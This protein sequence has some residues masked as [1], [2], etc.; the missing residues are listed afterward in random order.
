MISFIFIN[1]SP[2]TIEISKAAISYQ[3][4]VSVIIY[5]FTCCTANPK[6]LLYFYKVLYKWAYR[7]YLSHIFYTCTESAQCRHKLQGVHSQMCYTLLQLGTIFYLK[8]PTAVLTIVHYQRVALNWIEDASITSKS[9][10]LLSGNVYKIVSISTMWN[11]AN[12]LAN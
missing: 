5:S 4:Q 11:E 9:L 10:V 1:R 7:M 2:Q 3:I 12:L 8:N 6:N